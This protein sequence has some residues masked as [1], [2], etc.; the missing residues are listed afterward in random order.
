M[1]RNYR[2]CNKSRGPAGRLFAQIVFSRLPSSHFNL[3]NWN[4]QAWK[5]GDHL[6]PSRRINLQDAAC[7]QLRCFGGAASFQTSKK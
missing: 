2:I 3:Q 7:L 4:L 5:Q 1:G 6:P